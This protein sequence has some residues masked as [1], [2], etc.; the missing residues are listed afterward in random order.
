MVQGLFVVQHACAVLLAK[1]S[2]KRIADKPNAFSFCIFIM[3]IIV[4]LCF[5]TILLLQGRMCVN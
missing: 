5:D 2:E 3:F 1:V 4:H